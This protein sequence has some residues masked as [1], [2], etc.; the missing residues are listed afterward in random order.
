M[1]RTVA[2]EDDG[3]F[4]LN[5]YYLGVAHPPG[6]PLHTLFGKFFTLFPFGT[7]ASRVH[8]LSAFFGSLTC[9]LVWLVAFLL[10]NSR[11]LAY[12]A[13]LGY[14]FS[15]AFWS[16]A[17]IAEVY[18][19]NTF[20][21][22]LLLFLLL[23]KFLVGEQN[24]MQREEVNDYR[25]KC[26]IFGLSLLFGLSLANHWPLMLLS[27]PALA[28]IVYPYWR[29]FL[30]N[31][32]CILVGVLLGLTP[33]LWMFV[34]SQNN[35]FIS[36]LGPINNFDDLL[37]YVSRKFYSETDANLSAGLLDKLYFCGF[38]LS[39][40]IKQY[41][42]LGAVFIVIGLF[43]QWRIWPMRL[44]FSLLFIYIG[45]TFLLVL[46]LNYD[47]DY[48]NRALFKVYPLLAYGVLSL[49]LVFGLKYF[50]DVVQR[51]LKQKSV[52][53]TLKYSISI[54]AI[55]FIFITNF[56]Q[57]DRHAY[58]WAE[59]N[60]RTILESLEKDSI[61]F[62][63]SD[64]DLG[65]I[66]YLNLVENVRADVTLYNSYGSMFSN[67]LFHPIGTSSGDKLEIKKTFIRTATR[68]VY[69]ISEYPRDFGYRN[70]WL[71]KRVVPGNKN[72]QSFS[73]KRNI[74]QYFV[75]ITGEIPDNDAW[76]RMHRDILITRVISPLVQYVSNN[77]NNPI[78]RKFEEYIEIASQSYVGKLELV[79]AK[80]AFDK[81]FSY[82]YLLKL[83]DEAQQMEEDTHKK[84][85]RARL[86][87]YRG[88]LLYELGNNELALQNFQEAITI[89]PHPDNEATN[90]LKSLNAHGRY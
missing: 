74:L 44:C 47:Y 50:I 8:A 10:L 82:D 59:R 54:F 42:P 85:D 17:I 24:Q 25:D 27:T 63:D 67:R 12:V 72:S 52:E 21:F 1:P 36:F 68:P 15:L 22:F 51:V 79:N 2:L 88:G 58:N 55:L 70:Y 69:L 39:E 14:A 90:I 7:V 46:F 20:F 32:V 26:W 38:V 43:S 61:L 60:A 33:Y 77:E 5:S 80:R 28:M 89:W 4:I 57:N 84:R 40:S 53:N 83:L 66:G 37:I 18:T 23:L 75:L 73:L 65:P 6:Y 31:V 81:G 16:Q 76:S 87:I 9:V 19:L 86:R 41:S 35:L 29:L 71:M 62:V 56:A 45:S 30:R 13:G 49:W 34:H 64:V 78:S 3:L 11:S 48:N